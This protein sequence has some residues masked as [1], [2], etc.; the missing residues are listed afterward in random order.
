MGLNLHLLAAKLPLLLGLL[1][2]LLLVKSTV[3]TVLSR[4][5]GLPM[6]VGAA[7]GIMLAQG[8]EFGFVLFSLARQAEV[9]SSDTAQVA[10]LVIGMSM[11]ITPALLA[12]SRA[13]LRRLEEHP[14]VS[15]GSL[16]EDTEKISDHVII[17]GFGRVGQ[18]LGLLLESRFIP[19][20]ALDLNPELVA[21]A[22]Q[23]GRPVFFGDASRADVLKAAG[24]E[25]ARLAVS[26]LDDPGIAGRA[27]HVLR[28]LMP[29]LPI[30]ARGRD[31][32]DCEKL[33]RVGA[34]VAVP[35]IVEGS[36]Q[37]GGVLL[38]QL[39]E[40]PDRVGQL[41][42]Q[43]RQQAYARLAEITVGQRR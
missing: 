31:A 20:V 22:R 1:L 15:H 23:Q 42:E 34:T 27:V 35:E 13:V 19:Y 18:T 24:L 32:A 16:V 38:R 26:T 14:A 25:Q 41:L 39:G 11:A 4:A 29:A 10:M 2:A 40:S 28:R 5:F 3:L 37:L 36:L 8:S 30:L 12:T 43:F 7:V 9:I 33:V 17:A 6:A 21:E